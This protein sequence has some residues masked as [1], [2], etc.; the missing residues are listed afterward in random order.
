MFG[1]LLPCRNRR[2]EHGSERG[3]PLDDESAF[4]EEVT[5]D[6]KIRLLER[7]L[8]LLTWNAKR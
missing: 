8:C 3:Y 4:D 5:L 1:H 7:F 6:D 2:V